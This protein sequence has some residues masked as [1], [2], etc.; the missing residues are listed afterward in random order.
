MADVLLRLGDEICGFPAI[1]AGYAARTVDAWQ[2][3]GVGVLARELEICL[4][5]A[6][7]LVTGLEDGGYLI[8]YTGRSR[9]P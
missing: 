7:A 3:C 9:R 8:R 1:Q 4:P 2:W 5:E 6:R